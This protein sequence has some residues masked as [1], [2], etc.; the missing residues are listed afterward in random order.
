MVKGGGLKSYMKICWSTIFNYTNSVLSYKTILKN[1]F[2]YVNLEELVSI[3]EPIKKALK[4]LEF[5]S[6]TL[7]DY[8]IKIIK[9]YATIKNLPETHQV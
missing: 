7:A 1:H 4:Y 3:I 5:K 8:F 6:T 9:L 2:Y